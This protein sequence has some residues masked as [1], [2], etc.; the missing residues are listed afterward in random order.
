MKSVIK[1]HDSGNKV[2][3]CRLGAVYYFLY[4]SV[5]DLL[6][7]MGSIFF[8]KFVSLCAIIIPEIVRGI[9]HGIGHV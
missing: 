6:T 7:K 1:Q 3:R 9:V 5:H 8:L 4:D 2:V